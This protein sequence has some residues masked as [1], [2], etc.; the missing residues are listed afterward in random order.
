MAVPFFSARN[1]E[2]VCS[3]EAFSQLLED[4]SR[5]SDGVQ[6]VKSLLITGESKPISSIRATIIVLATKEKLLGYLFSLSL[7]LTPIAQYCLESS[8]G[9]GFIE[10]EDVFWQN[11]SRLNC[12]AGAGLVTMG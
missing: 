3:C 1:E 11:V 9:A 10:T 6:T 2:L 4:F 8:Q 5:V 12:S 7:F